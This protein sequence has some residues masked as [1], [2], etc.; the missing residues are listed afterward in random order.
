LASA[1]DAFLD[2]AVA[3][4]TEAGR[5][6]DAAQALLLRAQGRH[7][8]GEPEGADQDLE[9]AAAWLSRVGDPDM[10]DRLQ[11]QLWLARA[12][13]R[14]AAAD[15]G[16]LEDLSRALDYYA[17]SSYELGLAEIWLER[18]RAYLALGQ[19]DDAQRDFLSSIEMLESHRRSVSEELTRISYFEQARE[20][21]DE[22]I[23][24]QVDRRADPAAAFAFAERSRARELL[25]ALAN[26]ESDP[27]RAPHP[28]E[29]AGRLP[30]GASALYYA[31]LADRLLVWVISAR[32]IHYEE[33]PVGAAELA[34]RVEAFFDALR[35]EAR[36]RRASEALYD[37]LVRP[38]SSHLPPGSPVVVLPDKALHAVAFAAL[39]DR[40]SGRYLIEDHALTVAPS[41]TILLASAPG[42]APDFRAA[43]IL[44][45]GNPDFDRE[46]HAG[47]DPLPEAEE[48]A[49][50]IA[51]LYDASRVRA[52]F[53]AQATR[54]RVLELAER[55]EI[56]HFA[57]H[58]VANQEF[59]LL[60]RL[61]LS[62]ASPE[63]EPGELW[64][65]EIYSLRFERTR[66]VVLSACSTARSRISSGEGMLSLVRPFL[67]GGVPSV[68]ASLWPIE[69]APTSRL[70]ELFHRQLASGAAPA[71]ALRAA[72]L[73][74][75]AAADPEIRSPH[76]WAAF[77]VYGRNVF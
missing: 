35:D 52:L 33:L 68:V 41:A 6:T 7:R 53:G 31:S 65:H 54:A 77:Q 29:L 44:V 37:D 15:D 66:L 26:A 55:T 17:A 18:G 27:R 56:F 40:D 10:A 34:G 67:A 23:G 58:A 11:G 1:A 69:D 9:E 73:G 38:V 25:D 60:S 47:L 8:V 45:V 76:A 63:G 14:G 24:L 36:S 50:R 71:E 75:L 39:R 48:E 3:V 43:S 30:R 20:V 4:A 22:M 21:F 64:A 70:F 12:K 13:V 49:R 28:A 42:P 2:E 74:M 57:G 72:Q 16:V 19:E 51:G 46:R 32:G 61:L 62:P 5:A 59:P